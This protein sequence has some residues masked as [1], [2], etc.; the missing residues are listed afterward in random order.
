[1]MV[2]WR[3]SANQIM[4]KMIQKGVVVISYDI[5]AFVCMHVH[6]VC[7]SNYC[8]TSTIVLYCDYH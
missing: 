7:L 5:I 6:L 4:V 3:S 2:N 1:M 8:T